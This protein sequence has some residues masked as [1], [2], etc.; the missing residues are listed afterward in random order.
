VSIY[1]R[2]HLL[3]P[4]AGL[5]MTNTHEFQQIMNQ[6]IMKLEEGLERWMKLGEDGKQPHVIKV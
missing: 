5:T 3:G 1:A 4:I 6:S 2:N